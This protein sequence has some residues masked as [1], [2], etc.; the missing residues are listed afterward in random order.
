MPHK[1]LIFGW[2]IMHSSSATED[3]KNNITI[4]VIY[5]CIICGAKEELVMHA[6]VFCPLFKSS[7]KK[8]RLNWYLLELNNAA[9]Y[10]IDAL[11]SLWPFVEISAAYGFALVRR[12]G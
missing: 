2:K 8:M 5:T 10:S 12:S 1:V 9:L 6:L 4:E 7:R 3:K 11:V